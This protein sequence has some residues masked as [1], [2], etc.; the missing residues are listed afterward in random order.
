MKQK[1]VTWFMNDYKFELVLCMTHDLWFSRRESSVTDR[2]RLKTKRQN[3]NRT[4]GRVRAEMTHVKVRYSSSI[5]GEKKM[6][7]KWKNANRP[8]WGAD[9]KADITMNFLKGDI[10]ILILA[11]GKKNVDMGSDM[12]KR[13]WY[14]CSCQKQVFI[15]VSIW[16][17]DVAMNADMRMKCWYECWHE[18]K[19]L[20]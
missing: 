16:S 3:S 14:E 19:M 12:R 2:H 20:A 18:R 13:W 8:I 5:K 7:K 9:I 10:D 11:W 1:P 6:K 4:V 15:W 17:G